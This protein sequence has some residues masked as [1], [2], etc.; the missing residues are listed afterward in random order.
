MDSLGEVG[1]ANVLNVYRW[2]G[3]AVDQS[4]ELTLSTEQNRKKKT[5]KN[6]SC[7]IA[8]DSEL[9]E[10]S[11]LSWAVLH[12]SIAIGISKWYL[13]VRCESYSLD[14]LH[15]VSVEREAVSLRQLSKQLHERL[16]ANLRHT[17]EEEYVLVRSSRIV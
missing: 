17:I 9:Q 7:Y 11:L 5:M 14:S 16:R 12:A 3:I 13:L 8:V 2:L 4:D 10:C 15:L 1:E 6:K